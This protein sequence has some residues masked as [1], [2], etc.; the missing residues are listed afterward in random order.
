M[1]QSAY[2]L[3]TAVTVAILAGIALALGRGLAWRDVE[4][5]AGDGV[6]AAE[7]DMRV[8]EGLLAVAGV[9]TLAALVARS[10]LT[11]SL[12]VGP[13]T[14]LLLLATAV[15]TGFVSWGVYVA[16]RT[17]GLGYA[18]AVG[19]SVWLVGVLFSLAVVGQLALGL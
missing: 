16:A 15:L 19:L 14:G 1:A 5:A 13:G 6:A 4:A 10:P 7:R 17:R 11:G 3:S 9:A 12:T 18:A 2:L 8:V